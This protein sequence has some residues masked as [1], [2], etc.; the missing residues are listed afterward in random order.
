MN[1][2][3][4]VFCKM[5][6]SNDIID[7]LSSEGQDFLVSQPSMDKKT[8]RSLVLN[9]KSIKPSI[10]WRALEDLGW[11][12][13]GDR[14]LSQ[15]APYLLSSVNNAQTLYR[16][17]TD[18]ETWE[19]ALWKARVHMKALEVLA[20]DSQLNYRVGS[21]DEDFLKELVKLSRDPSS[22]PTLPKMLR[23]KGV[24]L[25]FERSLPSLKTDGL[26]Y[27]I[28]NG[29]P[30]IALS[31]RYSRLDNF[32][33]TFLHEIAH[34]IK[35]YDLLD[36]TIIEDLDSVPISKIEKQAN[37]FAKNT[38]VPR[39]I[40]ERCEAKYTHSL[41]SVNKLAEQLEVHP[42]L[43]AGMLRRDLN[44]YS[45]F[46]S[47]VGGINTREIVFGGTIMGYFRF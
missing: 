43:I 25:I 29:I 35:H 21:L 42:A 6:K 41:S 20:E 18:G 27:R 33:F 11:I 46:S 13:K 9:F 28:G 31:F 3:P 16:K 22:I 47:V 4:R 14:S 23:E 40:W 34:V 45:L 32:W 38:I 30:V 2:N 24:I 1:I 39:F 12:E 17:T 19:I 8:L 10:P 15:I 5:E 37:R 36:E 44:N 7:R 26:V